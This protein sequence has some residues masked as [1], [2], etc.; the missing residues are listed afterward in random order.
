MFSVRRSKN[1]KAE[2][3][4]IEKFFRQIADNVFPHFVNS[5][6]RS[7]DG[8]IGPKIDFIF[9]KAGHEIIRAL[10]A[11]EEI[12]LQLFLGGFQ[13]SVL[14]RAFLE[15]VELF[16]DDFDDLL[17]G[18]LVGPR[19]DDHQ[20]GIN[21]RGKIGVNRIG[22]PAILAD[23]LEKPRTHPPSEDGVQ[24]VRSKPKSVVILKTLRAEAEMDLL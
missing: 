17:E 9:R 10:E 7:F 6:K 5:L 11:E 24:E 22:Q 3:L 8:E 18:T 12:P 13:F 23:L 14:E 19:I 15:A 4:F 20:T 16:L 21:V 1:R 2:E